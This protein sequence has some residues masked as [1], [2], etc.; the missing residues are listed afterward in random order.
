MMTFQAGVA[1]R[2]MSLF[3]RPLDVKPI[4]E[5]FSIFIPAA[6]RAA[7]MSDEEEDR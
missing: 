1:Y 4:L 6:E 2:Q 3:C 7:K 5:T